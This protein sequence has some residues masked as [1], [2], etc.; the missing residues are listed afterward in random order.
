MCMH[1]LRA[2][3]YVQGD[4]GGC[5]RVLGPRIIEGSELELKLEI[6]EL[7]FKIIH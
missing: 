4:P 6:N 1:I 3:I 2:N 7:K 5:A